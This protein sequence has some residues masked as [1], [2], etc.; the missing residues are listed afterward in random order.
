MSLRDS[1][2]NPYSSSSRPALERY[3]KALERVHS[4]YVD[5]LAE[6]DATLQEDPGFVM[7]HAT[8]AGLAILFGD[9]AMK[10]MLRQSIEAGEQLAEQANDRE[11]RH[12]AAASCWL[13]GDFVQGLRR[14]GEILVDYPRDSLALHVAHV[15]DFFLG[16]ST[17]LRDRVAQVLPYWDSGVPFY[18]YVLGQHAFGLEEC[19]E[20]DRAEERGRRALELNPRDPWAI[21]AVAHVMEMQGRHAD[22]I[23]W[24]NSR[25]KDWSLD[26]AFAIHNWWHLA[27]YHL[28][29]GD[30]ERVLEIYDGY[31]RAQPSSYALDMLDASAMLWRM[32]LRGADVGNRWEELANCWETT[33]ADGFYAFNDVHAM[34]SFVGADRAD[35]MKRLLAT[36]ERRAQATGT[37]AM[38]TRDVGLPFARALKDFAEGRYEACLDGLAAIRTI[39][40]RF[41]GSNAQRDLVNL[42]MIEAA[43]RA[44]R[45]RQA[46]ALVSERTSFKPSS[47]FNWALSARSA[48]RI[49]DRDVADSISRKATWQAL[50]TAGVVRKQLGE[51]AA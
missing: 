16:Q 24:L 4:F 48:A 46:F 37:N 30:N 5:P 31:I 36:L 51:L 3:E 19:N 20:F 15:G 29:L 28:D 50:E 34:M 33:I 41:G 38:M 14:Y 13:D 1:R 49:G 35:S 11:R 39:V 25:R 9:N 44:G 6:L 23:D 7:A 2:G 26:N 12:L 18:G 17:M 27:L 22:G 43:H 32:Q 10:P 21:H 8:R 40:H 47:P 45:H 42:T